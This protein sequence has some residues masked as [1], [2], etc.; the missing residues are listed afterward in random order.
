KDRWQAQLQLPHLPPLT[1]TTIDCTLTGLFGF[2]PTNPGLRVS[3]DKVRDMQGVYKL[4]SLTQKPLRWT[5]L[6]RAID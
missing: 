2:V 1:R 5:S 6:A 3:L 4:F